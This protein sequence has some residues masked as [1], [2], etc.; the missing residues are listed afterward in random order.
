MLLEEFWVFLLW[1]HEQREGQLREDGN[2]KQLW[3]EGGECNNCTGQAGNENN[4][5]WAGLGA[6]VFTVSERLTAEWK[7]LK[8]WH[9]IIL[10]SSMWQIASFPI[11]LPRMGIYGNIF[12]SFNKYLLSV[13]YYEGWYLETEDTAVNKAKFLSLLNWCSSWRADRQ[14][15]VKCVVARWMP[16]RKIKEGWQIEDGRYA[17][18]YTDNQEGVSPRKWP[19]KK[20]W[21]SWKRAL[22]KSAGKAF[23]AAETTKH[24]PAQRGKGIRWEGER[25]CWVFQGIDCSSSSEQIAKASEFW[26]EE[27]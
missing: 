11:P 16:R 27:W 5:S 19:W 6:N 22:Q 26:A 25:L 23:Q 17:G 21:K 1:L 12:H 7:P 15:K 10:T 20:D 8:I 2:E 18:F 13:S 3:A 14:N 9:Q 24:L 4:R